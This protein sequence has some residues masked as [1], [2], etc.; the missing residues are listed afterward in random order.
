MTTKYKK[1]IKDIKNFHSKVS[2][3]IPKF[4][5]FGHKINVSSGNPSEV[6]W[7]GMYKERNL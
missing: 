7:V 5:V 6:L 2:Q 3:N 4:G 1:V